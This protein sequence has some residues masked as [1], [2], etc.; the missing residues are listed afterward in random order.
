MMKRAFAAAGLAI[1][2]WRA[3]RDGHDTAAFVDEVEA[4]LGYPCF[5]KPAN[6]GSSV[7]VSKARGRAELID[8]IDVAL[9]LRRV[10]R[11]G[12]GDQRTRDRGR[13]A[14]RRS[15]GGVGAGRDRARRRLLHV[16]RQVRAGR[17]RTDRARAA[18]VR[19]DGRGAGAR[20]SIVRGVP[21]RG[22]G[23]GRLLPRGGAS[24]RGTGPRVPRERGQHDPGLHADLDVP[25]A[26]GR[27]RRLVPGAAATGSS[28]SRWRA[29]RATGP[30]RGP[31]AR[32]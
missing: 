28:T 27:V 3:L 9:R 7:G 17:R 11:R 30:S 6:L 16:R 13:R 5:V 19:A 4:K 20:G 29:A 8:A 2:D 23:T 25:A 32:R 21:L 1:A 10:D 18:G 12:G 22:D 26:L 31:P 14:R 15:A 24:R